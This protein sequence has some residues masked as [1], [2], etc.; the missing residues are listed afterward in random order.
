LKRERSAQVALEC[1]A[2]Q[3]AVALREHPEALR[4]LHGLCA[5]CVLLVRERP[6]LGALSRIVERHCPLCLVCEH[7][8]C[9]LVP[10]Y[11]REQVCHVSRD[12]VESR[13]AATARRKTAIIRSS[14]H[15][16][17]C[18]NRVVRIL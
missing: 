14:S 10:A 8:S 1:P 16:K 11:L 2:N 17:I 9:E 7:A 3:R 6:D 18:S 15:R 13:R 5:D 12:K 4:K